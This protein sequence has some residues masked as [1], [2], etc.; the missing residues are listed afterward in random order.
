VR[1]LE[2]LF[3]AAQISVGIKNAG[4]KRVNYNESK[5]EEKLEETYKHGNGWRGS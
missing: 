1:H 4:K 2:I 3:V 5:K